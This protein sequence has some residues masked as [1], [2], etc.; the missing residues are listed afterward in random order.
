MSKRRRGPQLICKKDNCEEAKEY[1]PNAVGVYKQSPEQDDLDLA[2]HV[3]IELFRILAGFLAGSE[4]NYFIV[5]VC[6]KRKREVGLVI[7]GCYQ[8]RTGRKKIA[9]ILST[10]IKKI[11]ERYP[12][13]ELEIEH[14]IIHKPMLIK[15]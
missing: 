12:Y 10:E 13:F 5:Q 6:G 11:K 14:D 3:P 4:S 15:Q 2:G 8:A 7:P 1:D 9:D